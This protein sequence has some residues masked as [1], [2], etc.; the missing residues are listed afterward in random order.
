MIHWLVFFSPHL[1]VAS[2]LWW[3]CCI[4]DFVFMCMSLIISP[5][6]NMHYL[7]NI[8]HSYCGVVSLRGNFVEECVFHCRDRYRDTEFW[9][10]TT[11]PSSCHI[12]LQVANLTT[13]SRPMFFLLVKLPTLTCRHSYE[14]QVKRKHASLYDETFDRSITISHGKSVTY[15]IF[16]RNRPAC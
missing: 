9:T 14:W 4:I 12:V 3:T 1:H 13:F 15:F 2:S 5:T 6:D 10:P 8:S 11:L 16:Q 7:L